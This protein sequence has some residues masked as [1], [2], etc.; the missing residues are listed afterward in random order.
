[1]FSLGCIQAMKC[2]SGQCPTGV[3]ASNPRLIAGLDPT[4]KAARVARYAIQVREEVAIIAHACG[5]TDPTGF[6]PTGTSPKS[7]AA[8]AASAPPKAATRALSG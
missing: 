5:L 7:S 1:M 8:S 3:T 6:P 4:D 2:G